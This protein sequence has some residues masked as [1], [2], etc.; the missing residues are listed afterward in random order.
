MGKEYGIVTYP[1]GYYWWFHYKTHKDFTDEQKQT[2]YQP[3][4]GNTKSVR[5]MKIDPI[6]TFANP[7]MYWM[8]CYHY[9]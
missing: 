3:Y 6:R 9:I 4:S 8:V 1:C 5:V 7:V 2:A